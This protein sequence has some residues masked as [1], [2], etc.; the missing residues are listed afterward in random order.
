MATATPMD[1]EYSRS[2]DFRAKARCLLD[3]ARDGLGDAV[4]LLPEDPARLG[5]QVPRLGLGP[6]A[7]ALLLPGLGQ[8]AHRAL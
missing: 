5:H 2:V 1:S 8:R 7:I 3:L 4:A 6:A